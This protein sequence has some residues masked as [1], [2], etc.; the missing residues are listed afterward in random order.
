MLLHREKKN[1]KIATSHMTNNNFVSYL[2]K[3]G[4]VLEN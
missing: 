2:Q 3:L 1:P 4:N